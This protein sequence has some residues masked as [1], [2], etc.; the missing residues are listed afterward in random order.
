MCNTT[1]H[2]IFAIEDEFKLPF[3]FEFVLQ[4]DIRQMDKYH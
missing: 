4:W 1:D 3:P 2:I